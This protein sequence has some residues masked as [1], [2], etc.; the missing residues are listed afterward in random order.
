MSTSRRCSRACWSRAATSSVDPTF[1]PVAVVNDRLAE[2]CRAGPGHVAIRVDPD[3]PLR[4]ENEVVVTFDP[5]AV[6]KV[7]VRA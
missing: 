7:N 4:E 2:C 5:Y 3:H 6:V 1:P